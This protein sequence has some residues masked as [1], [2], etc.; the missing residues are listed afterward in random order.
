MSSEEK[1]QIREVDY[2]AVMMQRDALVKKAAYIRR[3]LKRCLDAWR[4]SQVDE[5]VYEAERCSQQLS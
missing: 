5:L 2:L 4:S 1:R 3:L